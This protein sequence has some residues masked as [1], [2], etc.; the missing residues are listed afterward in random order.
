MTR[1][2]T[3]RLLA[4]IAAFDRRTVG[5]AD[6]IAWSDVL[7]D[8]TPAE[9]V[10]AV[11]AHFAR[12]SEWLMPAHVVAE[13]RL[14]RQRAAE[15]AWAERLHAELPPVPPVLEDGHTPGYRRAIESL[16]EV[17]PS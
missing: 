10:D 11:R 17:A 9:C 7:G 1:A 16:R 2:D 6:V 4:V 5:E 12:S 14:V 3:A 8:C 13:V 15:H